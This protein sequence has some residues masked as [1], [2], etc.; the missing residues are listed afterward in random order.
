MSDV[1][2]GGA[3]VATET[4]LPIGSRVRVILS[5]PTAWDP[6]EVAATVRWISEPGSAPEGFGIR[7]EALSGREAAALYE[8]VH[9]SA[10][11]ESG[12]VAEEEPEP[13]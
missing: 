6:I 5:S 8:L 13:E 10:Y 1:G 7:F 2:V 3:F 12:N 4:R 9:V 11:A